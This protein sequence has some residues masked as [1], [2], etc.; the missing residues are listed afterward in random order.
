MPIA[1]SG[2]TDF[3]PIE[4]GLHPAIC[5]GIY[6]LGVQPSNNPSFKDAHKVLL[7]FEVTGERGQFERDGKLTDLPRAISKEYTLSIGPKSNLLRDLNGWRGKPFTEEEAKGF[8]IGVLSGVNCMLNITHKVSMSN[9]KTYANI[10]SIVPP[11]KGTAKTTAENKLVTFDLPKTGSIIIPEGIPE[12]ISKK[13]M[14][15]VQYMEQQNPAKAQAAAPDTTQAFPT[16]GID[17]DD[18]PF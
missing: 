15:S 1:T 16:S 7:N 13:I 8:E 14:N 2:G 3:T 4:A 5:F 12:W 10:T 11:I 9:Q 17:P 18:V 6:D